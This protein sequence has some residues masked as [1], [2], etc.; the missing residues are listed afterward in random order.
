MKDPAHF[1]AL[2]EKCRALASGVG[3]EELRRKLLIIADDYD[4][5]AARLEAEPEAMPTIHS[6][7]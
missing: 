1:R 5:Q 6:A 2:A 3:T 7:E 4:A